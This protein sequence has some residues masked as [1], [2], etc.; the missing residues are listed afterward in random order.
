MGEI[1]SFWGDRRLLRE[2]CYV[3]YAMKHVLFTV[4]TIY[5]QKSIALICID[6]IP[7]NLVRI[8]RRLLP[9]KQLYP[10]TQWCQ[11]CQW[12]FLLIFDFILAFTDLQGNKDGCVFPEPQPS[13]GL[14]ARQGTQFDKFDICH[15]RAVLSAQLE[16]DVS[17][18]LTP[19]SG[20]A[21]RLQ[22]LHPF[23]AHWSCYSA[24]FK[25][26]FDWGFD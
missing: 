2:I 17:M 1:W 4:Y 22:A 12:C 15:R 7:L 8:I 25:D 21:T 14:A 24:A 10:E 13:G 16:R 18:G 26:Q 19:T 20:A 5:H 23:F 6:R 11:W 3:K 9:S